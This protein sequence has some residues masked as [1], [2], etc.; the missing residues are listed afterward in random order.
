LL[1]GGGGS[2][3]FVFD[4]N[5]LQEANQPVSYI[6]ANLGVTIDSGD[7]K[8]ELSGV[9]GDR[10]TNGP[11]TA[12]L[13]S[14]DEVKEQYDAANG[15]DSYNAEINAYTIYSLSYQDQLFAYINIMPSSPVIGA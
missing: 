1:V 6:V 14:V 11:L 7:K 5:I 15:V 8:L 9:L 12:K 4:W 2:D 10:K 13:L 3:T